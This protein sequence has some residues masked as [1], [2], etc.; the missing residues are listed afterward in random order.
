MSWNIGRSYVIYQ[1]AEDRNLRLIKGL[2]IGLLWLA[3]LYAADIPET[4]K[5]HI[6]ERVA[7]GL[8]QGIVIA[9]ID[10]DG[11][12]IFSEGT[13]KKGG[14]K[15]NE[16]KV[17]EIGSISKTFTTLIL[18]DMVQKGE[19]SLDDPISK[20]LPDGVKA[21]RYKGQDITL[22]HLAT[23]RSSLPRMPA[24]FEPSNPNDPYADYDEALLY[25]FLNSLELD[26]DIGSQFAYSNL[27]M[28]LLGTLLARVAN[29]DYE[30][31]L[32]QRVLDP[33]KMKETWVAVTDQNREMFA[34]GHSGGEQTSNW[35]MGSLA[36]AGTVKATL[37]DMVTY[38]S[39]QMGLKPSK[40]QKAMRLSQQEYQNYGMGLGWMFE[41]ENILQH[42]GA[43]G[44]YQAYAAM[45]R[46]GSK[47]VVVLT[48]SDESVRT[49]G[50]HVLKPELELPPVRQHIENALTSIAINEGAGAAIQKY[51]HYK[52][53]YPEEYDFSEGGLNNLGYHLLRE[54]KVAD[55]IAIFELNVAENP[56]SSNT[57]DSLGEAYKIKGNTDMAIKHYSKSIDLNPNNV[58]AMNMLKEMGTSYQRKE[59]ELSEADLAPYLGQFQLNERLVFTVSHQ[60]SQLL[61]QLTGQGAIP[62][63]PTGKDR[64]YAKVVDAQISFNRAQDGRVESLTLHQNGSHIAPRIEATN[65]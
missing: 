45:L 10:A 53:N 30:T 62:V 59:Q 60:G 54:D 48:N 15:L 27:G 39:A 63:F 38:M 65:D 14:D 44:G 20:Y 32:Q 42:G 12:A 52:V 36:G 21:P 3:P 9:V 51:I 24:N 35:H 26:R 16:H 37:A 40:L 41:G 5:N 50:L 28:G 46:D 8:N 64:F 2:L 4:A 56:Q 47:G 1:Q 11:V 58:N 29:T 17:F 31:L 7:K 49:L 19:V 43:T 33:L 61:V 22:G 25:A 34:F 23:H 55:A 57:Y 18:A 13:T 6:R